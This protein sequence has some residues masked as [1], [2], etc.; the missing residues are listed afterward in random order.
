MQCE[1]LYPLQDGETALDISPG[2]TL[3][4]YAA[5]RGFTT[6][7]EHLLSTPGFDVDNAF[8]TIYY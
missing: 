4:C 3:L 8:K 5:R 7:V 1:M 6:C 2:D